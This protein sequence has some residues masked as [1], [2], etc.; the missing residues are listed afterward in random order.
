LFSQRK[1]LPV[2][3]GWRMGRYIESNI[4]VGRMVE[5]LNP[6]SSAFDELDIIPEDNVFPITAYNDGGSETGFEGSSYLIRAYCADEI[7]AE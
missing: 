4:K 3:T 5:C 7:Y 1:E 2:L 6:M